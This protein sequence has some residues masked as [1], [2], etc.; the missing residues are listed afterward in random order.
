MVQN[1][2]ELK[3]IDLFNGEILTGEQIPKLEGNLIEIIRQFSGQSYCISRFTG[4]KDYEG[5]K[6]F[7][8]DYV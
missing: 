3:V 5:N 6:L 2:I 1:E 4:V 8:Y 7:E